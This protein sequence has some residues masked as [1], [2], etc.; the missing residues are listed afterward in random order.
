MTKRLPVIFAYMVLLVL[1]L[2]VPLLH[3]YQTDRAIETMRPFIKMPDGHYAPMLMPVPVLAL[4]WLGQLSYYVP[5]LI[6][7]LLLLSFCWEAL[8]ELTTICS[9]AICQCAFTT[10]YALYATW[11]LGMYCLKNYII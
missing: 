9:V 4:R 1:S 7:A 6:L 5:F 8:T 2:P 11:L 3:H 10:L